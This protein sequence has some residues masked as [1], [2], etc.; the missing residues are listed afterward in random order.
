[1]TLREDVDDFVATLKTER[2]ELM[3]KMHLAKAE[4]KDEWDKAEQKW[5][6]LRA[7]GERLGKELKFAS[8]EIAVAAKLLGEEIKE[9]YARIRRVL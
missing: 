1:M 2:D 3:L 4:A 6:Q 9:A 5:A 7:R 8:G